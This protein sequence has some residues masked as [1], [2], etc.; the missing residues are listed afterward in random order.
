MNKIIIQGIINWSTATLFICVIPIMINKAGMILLTDTLMKNR[1]CISLKLSGSS[2]TFSALILNS[3]NKGATEKKAAAV[4]KYVDM[5]NLSYLKQLEY[6]S[7]YTKSQ[8]IE[9]HNVLKSIH[10]EVRGVKQM[11][12]LEKLSVS[13]NLKQIFLEIGEEKEFA[14]DSMLFS[15]GED[16]T[17]IYIVKAGLIKVGKLSQDGREISIRLCREGD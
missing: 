17:H 16:A 15:E 14:K 1:F 7:K 6:P 8:P 2:L 13:D 10:R 3:T 9:Q 5:N 12:P 11:P 4:K